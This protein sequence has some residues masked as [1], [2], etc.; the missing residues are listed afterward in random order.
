VVD[1]AHRLM[2]LVGRVGEGQA[3][4]ARRELE[5]RQDGVAEG[6]G[7]DAGAVGDEKTVRWVMVGLGCG[8]PV[9]VAPFLRMVPIMRTRPSR[10][11]GARRCCRAAPL[12]AVALRAACRARRFSNSELSHVCT[13]RRPPWSYRLRT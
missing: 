9:Q 10:L 1:L 11:P 6:F 12:P 4:V 3:H 13:F 5:L 2:R 8:R 7:R